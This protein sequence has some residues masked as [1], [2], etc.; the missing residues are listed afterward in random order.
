[1]FLQEKNNI[2]NN[3]KDGILKS[4]L[5]LLLVIVFIC[6][7]PSYSQQVAN[8]SGATL[9]N[10]THLIEYS[11]GEVSITTLSVPGKDATQ[12]LLQPAIKVQNPGCDIIN[13]DI[14]F[15]ENATKNKLRIVG[16]HD[17]IKSYQVYAS[18]GRLVR[19]QAFYNNFIDVSGL[20]AAGIYFIRLLPGCNGQ[21]KVLKFMKR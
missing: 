8:S 20:P 15:F 18:D 13:Q 12:G 17:W 10:T 6:N 5:K 11:V 1:M 2:F 16:I 21:Y 19:D 7:G 14:S 9:Q 3:T 4:V